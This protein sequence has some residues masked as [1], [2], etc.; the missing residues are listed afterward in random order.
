MEKLYKLK[1]QLL[2]L[3]FLSE[4]KRIDNIIKSAT[5]SGIKTLGLRDA[6]ARLFNSL[7]GDKW[8][9]VIAKWFIEHN[10]HRGNFADYSGGFLGKDD[11]IQII[12]ALNACEKLLSK[13]TDERKEFCEKDI[14]CKNLKSWVR[15]MDF[16]FESA[17]E[18][19]EWDE[20]SLRYSRRETSPEPDEIIQNWMEELK[21]ALSEKV[22]YFISIDF[23]REVIANKVI[24]PSQAKDK[25]FSEAESAWLEKRHLSMPSILEIDD[26]WK[27]VDA[28]GGKSS[29][30]AKNLKNC[31]SVSW[32]NLRATKE[33]AVK[34]RMLILMDPENK[35]HA[36]VT[37]N[38]EY[39]DYEAEKKP[40][41]KYLGHIEGIAGSALKPEYYKYFNML[42]DYLDPDSI[43]ISNKKE[44]NS[45]YKMIA[46]NDDLKKLMNEERLITR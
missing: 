39:I 36:M 45:D 13:P 9:Y 26:G 38:P 32:G 28:G 1:S 44:Y 46:D 35:P 25:T 42:V 7:V 12:K 3:G 6:S 11:P 20:W 23:V 15:A 22:E 2:K 41:Q 40:P 19:E 17:W 16:N 18:K 34:A 5:I 43:Y 8:D 4:S 27:W 37:W 31:G 21:S 10:L 24:S 30:V 33:S 14:D 29:W